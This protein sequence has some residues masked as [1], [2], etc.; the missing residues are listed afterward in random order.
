MRIEI[1]PG[2]LQSLRLLAEDAQLETKR[3]NDD[4]TPGTHDRRPKLGI[5]S[6]HANRKPNYNMVPK[7]GE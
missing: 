5:I 3:S 7:I 1:R 2:F 4:S 6:K